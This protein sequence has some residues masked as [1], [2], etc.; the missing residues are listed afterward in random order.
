[1]ETST[2]LTITCRK[3]RGSTEG[4]LESSEMFDMTGNERRPCTSQIKSDRVLCPVPSRRIPSRSFAVAFG[5]RRG[6]LF[7]S[8]AN[9][10]GYSRE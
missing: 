6:G 2:S 7:P 9:S 4:D 5:N 1:M 10:K 3:G 8:G